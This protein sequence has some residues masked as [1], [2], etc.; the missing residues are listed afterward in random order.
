MRAFSRL[1]TGNLQL[2]ILSV[3]LRIRILLNLQFG[4]KLRRRV[5][6]YIATLPAVSATDTALN[7]A[8]RCVASIVFQMRTTSD[9]LI[10]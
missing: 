7:D 10:E 3:L 5:S 8:L 4:D 2:V 9:K 1:E 6:V